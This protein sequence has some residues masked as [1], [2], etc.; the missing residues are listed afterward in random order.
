MPRLIK[1]KL[2]IRLSGKDRRLSVTEKAVYDAVLGGIPLREI[3]SKFELSRRAAIRTFYNARFVV[4]NNRRASYG[5]LQKFIHENPHDFGQ[6]AVP[7][8]VA[9]KKPNAPSPKKPRAAPKKRVAKPRNRSVLSEDQRR[10]ASE[11][12]DR[13]VSDPHLP[14][15]EIS[16]SNVLLQVPGV[17]DTANSALRN[18]VRGIFESKGHTIR[19]G[20]LVNSNRVPVRRNAS[21]VRE[22]A[23]I[24]KNSPEMTPEGLSSLLTNAGHKTTPKLVEQSL[25][26]AARRGYIT[27]EKAD[28][29]PKAR[30]KK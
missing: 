22:V 16:V 25:R 28:L 17:K 4:V 8:P 18:T 10:I 9:E 20:Q 19:R 23:R 15:H 29:P 1:P 13:M 11:T 30:A 7:N 5:L 2:P 26:T 14:D 3:M 21:L 6:V 12:I 24:K 27:R